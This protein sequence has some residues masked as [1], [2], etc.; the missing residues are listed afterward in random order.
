MLLLG[1]IKVMG[2]ILFI[3][4]NAD[5]IGGTE[6][7]SYEEEFSREICGF[8]YMFAMLASYAAPGGI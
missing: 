7:A 6:E 4:D 3:A 8:P 2:F 5:A 1:V